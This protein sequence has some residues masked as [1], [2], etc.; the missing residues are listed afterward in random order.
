MGAAGGGV[1]PLRVRYPPGM[2]LPIRLL[3]VACLVPGCV[4]ADVDSAAPAPE[5]TDQAEPEGCGALELRVDGAEAPVVGDTWTVWLWCDDALLTGAMR[6]RFDPPD[7]ART[8]D[9]VAT[10]LY[11]GTALMTMQVGAHKVEQDVVVSE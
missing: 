4:G 7:F 9:N 1:A 5:D 3:L 10:F 2:D 8:D 6:L 11:A